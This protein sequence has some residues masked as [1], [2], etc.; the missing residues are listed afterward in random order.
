[1][2]YLD[3]FIQVFDQKFV[4]IF[5]L[6]RSTCQTHVTSW[7]SYWCLVKSTLNEASQNA[8]KTLYWEENNWRLY[9]ILMMHTLVWDTWVFGKN[10]PSETVKI[11]WSSRFKS[12]TIE[13]DN[14]FSEST[15]SWQSVSRLALMMY[16]LQDGNQCFGGICCLY[17]QE[18]TMCII[19]S[20]YTMCIISSI[21]TIFV[22]RL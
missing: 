6:M 10:V 21:H 17:L 19:T 20:M 7:S 12:K 8:H 11:F 18:H 2:L 1:V 15:F 4:Q 13:L 9:D 3:F 14:L 5:H 22:L 16:S